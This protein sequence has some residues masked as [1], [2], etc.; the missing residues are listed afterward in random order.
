ME[1]L[2]SIFNLKLFHIELEKTPKPLAAIVRTRSSMLATCLK[3]QKQYK[4]TL[5]TS[6]LTKSNF[7]MEFDS[8]V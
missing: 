8:E 4:L 5:Y 1:R 3:L 7:N 2:R 6:I